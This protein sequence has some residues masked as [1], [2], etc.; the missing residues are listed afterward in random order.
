MPRSGIGWPLWV[1]PVLLLLA[2]YASDLHSATAYSEDF[3]GQDGQGAV[4]PGPSTDL[5]GV[6]WTIDTSSANLSA[7]SDWFQVINGRLEARD[8]DGPAVWTAPTIDISGL[9]NLQ[10]SLSAVEDGDHE[11]SDYFD[12][13]Y[14]IDGGSFVTLTDWNN[15]GSSSHTLVGDRPDDADWGNETVTQA[16]GSGSSLTLRVTLRN[17]AGSERLQLDDVVVTG[18]G[19]GADAAPSVSSTT[20]SDGASDV[21][22]DTDITVTFSEAVTVQTGSWFAIDCTK[23]GTLGGTVSSGDSTTFTIDPDSAFSPGETC[24]VTVTGGAVSDLDT[25][26]PPDTASGDTRFSFAVA[27]DS[28]VEALSE[29]FEGSCPNGLPSGWTVFSVDTDATNTWACDSFSGDRFAEVNAFGASAPGDDWLITPALT[30]ANGDRLSFATAKNF[31]DSGI[32]QPLTVR[33]STDYSGSGDPTGATWSDVPGAGSISLSSGGFNEVQSGP[34]DLSSLAG[35]TLYIAFRYQSSGTGGGSTSLWQLDD[36]RLENAQGSGVSI[37]DIQGSGTVSPLE[38]QDVTVTGLVTG[39][40]EGQDTGLRGFYIQDPAGDGNLATSDGLFVFNGNRDDVSVGDNVTVSGPVSEFG[41]QTQVSAEQIIVNR[42]DQPLP[43]PTALDLPVPPADREALE[44]ML[45]TARDSGGD[46][47]YW[48]EYFNFDRFGERWISQGGRLEQFTL[49]NDPSPSG[50]A[51]HQAMVESRSLLVDDGQSGQNLV[52]LDNMRG[53]N[54]LG[55]GAGGPTASNIF[56]GGDTIST[57][58]GVLGEGFGNYRLQPTQPFSITPSSP[59]PTSPPTVGGQ[60]RV[61]AFNVLNY[62]NT[63]DSSNTQCGPSNEGC[64]GADAGLTDSQGRSELD[65]QAA[66]IVAAIDALDADVIGLIELENNTASFN[67]SALADL[68]DRLNTTGSA[69]SRYAGVDPG[70]FVGDDVIQVGFL[71]CTDT[72]GLAPGTTVESLDDSDLPGLGLSALAPVFNGSATNRSPLAA[73]FETV[74]D[75]ERFTV[76]VNHFKSKGDSGKAGETVCQ[77]NPSADLNCDQGDGQGFW[78]ARR[79]AAAEALAAWLANDPTNSGDADYLIMGDLNAYRQED[80]ITTLEQASYTN[81]IDA[82]FEASDARSG[83]SGPASFV[84]DRQWGAL[85]Y[86]FASSDL[87]GQV[88]GAD[89]WAINAD[90]I[91]AIDYDFSFNDESL[92]AP[93]VYRSSDHDPVL[94]GLDLGQC[95]L[96]VDNNTI[97]FGARDVGGTYGPETVT[98]T[99]TGSGACRI[100]RIAYTGDEWFSTNQRRVQRNVTPP[101]NPVQ[102]GTSFTVDVFYEVTGAGSHQASLQVASNDPDNSP[103]T[104]FVTGSGEVPGGANATCDTEPDGDVDTDDFRSIFNEVIDGD[105]EVPPRM[106]ADGDGVVTVKDVRLCVIQQ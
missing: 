62:F 47:L 16:L 9:S 15:R 13:A 37:M 57:I 86:A 74:V 97:D 31:S 5:T 23:S 59:R 4:G 90:E 99:N 29:D 82:F 22:V 30:I 102:P 69:C 18:D 21:A 10:L 7:S 38:N 58:T 43:S 68:V 88:A 105:T 44:G 41:E 63:L 24:E 81:L 85:D 100:D 76:V 17:N 54:S 12:V 55:G 93:D 26:D 50:F 34:I 14:A 48:T 106:D 40:F 98:F 67:N 101:L 45:V 78:N 36:V 3:S 91:D 94:V 19:A 80:P 53:G 103:L 95:N 32:A 1:L 52:P 83:L 2:P 65:R 51:A 20:P 35:N 46:A 49:N 56:R 104:V 27:G 72:V 39:D 25:D 33:Y 11:S 61:A 75:N 6:D 87:L 89:S 96:T 8:V 42:S 84:F 77:N 70:G 28:T 92:Y 79:S 66:K 64:R 73:T 60:I 71:Y